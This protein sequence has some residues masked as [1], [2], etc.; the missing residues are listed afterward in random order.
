MRKLLFLIIFLAFPLF[1]PKVVSAQNAFFTDASVQYIVSP[2]GKTTVIKTL[3]VENATSEMQSD[4][5]LLT[6]NSINPQGLE[7]SEDDLP[8]SFVQEKEGETLKVRIN[9]TKPV[10]GIGKKRTFTVKFSEDSFAVRTGEVWEIAIPRLDENA[11]FRKYDVSLSIPKNLGDEAYVSPDPDNT[12]YFAESNIYKFGKE[13]VINS[14]ISAGFGRFQVFTFTLNYHL[15]NPL[16]NE[17][18]VEV[19]L[20]PDTSTQKVF[21]HS[22]KPAPLNVRV[23]EDGNW[24]SLYKLKSRERLDLTVKG[25]VQILP[26]PKRG[27]AVKPGI[28]IKNLDET[29]YWQVNDPGIQKLAEELKTPEAIYNYVTDTLKYD[30]KRVKPNSERLGAKEALANPESAICTE[31]TD[32]FVALTRASGI[33]ARE[34]NGYAYTENPEIQPLSLVS[35]VLHSWPEY[36]DEKRATWVPVDPTWGATTGVDYFNKFDLR[37]F[38]FVIHGLDSEKPYPPGSYKLGPNP[39]KDVFVNFG[40]APINPKR[41]IALRN[42]PKGGLGFLTKNVLFTVANTGEAALYDIPL[43]VNFDGLEYKKEIIGILPPYSTYEL[44]V[45]VP[46][47]VLGSK[48]PRGVE[49][50]ALDK[51]VVFAT[52][53]TSVVALQLSV[54]FTALVILTLLFYLKVG[55]RK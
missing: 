50:T 20:P 18:E 17:E 24:L 14:G 22:I 26:A 40:Q 55:R 12:E 51:S 5:Y 37:H 9:F 39:Q 8:L 23:D 1:F 3:T 4:S 38:T 53:K 28:L 15:E 42:K 36:W 29:K 27:L 35:D 46:Y 49:L 21:Y 33:P 19:A 47:G 10:P 13:K 2:E 31:F 16:R 48:S 43:A 52:N 41:E 54:V 32:L 30:Y 7:V 45:K 6:L 11:G 44:E 34:I 25:S